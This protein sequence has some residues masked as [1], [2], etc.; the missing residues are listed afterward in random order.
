MRRNTSML[1]SHAVSS[2]MKLKHLT[3]TQVAQY[4]G[5]SY[6]SFAR[7]MDEPLSFT[8]G[9]IDKLACLFGITPAELIEGRDF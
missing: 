7:R 5:L 4:I 6:S 2:Q 9:E 3:K 1:L 8:A